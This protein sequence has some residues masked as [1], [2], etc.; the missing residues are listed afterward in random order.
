MLIKPID[1]VGIISIFAPWQALQFQPGKFKAQ[2]EKALL[3]CLQFG[4]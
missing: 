3:G 4:F 2:D 1:L